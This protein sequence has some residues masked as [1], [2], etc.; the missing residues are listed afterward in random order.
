MPQDCSELGQWVPRHAGCATACLG[1]ECV[2][3][4]AGEAMCKDGA[5][6]ECTAGQWN[7]LEL[8]GKACEN[9]A[10]V[11]G[12]TEDRL[13]CNGARWL[14]KCV[15]GSYVDE[16]ECPF[17]CSEGACVGEC[18]PD[19][20]RC[21][22]DAEGESQTCGADALWGA[23][24]PC[25]ANTFCVA[26]GCKPCRPGTKRCSDAGPQQCSEA[27]EWVNQG[28][29]V[30][31][32]PACLNGACVACTPGE[33]RCAAAAVEQCLMDGSGWERVAACS[34]A[35]PVCLETTKACGRCTQGQTQ[36]FG[37]EVRSCDDQGVWTTTQTCSGTTP[38]CVASACV[39]CDPAAGERRCETQNRAQSCSAAGSWGN[40]TTCSGDKPL[41]REDLN[42]SCGCEEGQRRCRTNTIP[43]VC[44]GGS[45]V[46]QTTCSGVLNHCL[47]ASG[48]CVDCVPGT[49]ECQSGTAYECTAQGAWRS[50]NSCAGPGINCGGCDLGEPCRQNSDCGSGVCV[51]QM[52][53][54]CQPGQRR[55]QGNVPQ[56]CSASGAWTN[57]SAC[58]G[59]TPQCLAST[60]LCVECLSGSRACGTCNGGT[61]T[62]G[63]NNAW[64]TCTNQP[65][66]QSSNAHCGA[67]N[68]ACPSGRSCQSG[69]CQCNSGTHAC[70]TTCYSNTDADRCGSGCVDCSAYHGTSNVCSGN[71]CACSVGS[72]ACGAN[73]PTCSSWDF[74]T[75]TE[76]WKRGSYYGPTQNRL[77]TPFSTVINNGSPAL[78]AHFEYDGMATRGVA[79]FSVDLCPNGS[80]TDL[81]GFDFSYKVYF[82]TT[83]SLRFAASEYVV[84]TFL[85]DG[86]TVITACQPFLYPSSDTWET[87]SCPSMPANTRN[88]TI[89]VRFNRAWTGDIYLDDVRFTPRR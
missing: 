67:C 3:C 12:C 32:T 5:V 27:G 10:C 24:E 59:A 68:N 9:G 49:A 47:P 33:K 8:C 51:N 56:L 23:S 30:A 44:Q 21:N 55:C 86:G 11:A 38:R 31:P 26:G 43:E 6:Q 14:Q 83:T 85:A 20:R 69:S 42:F 65:N 64:G 77:T 71:Q 89:V 73:V 58:S 50:L 46:A 82:R 72:F 34:G 54:V 87:G 16:T 78:T 13:Q 40:P 2:E 15:G 29:C 39:Q 37:N 45:W 63:T 1:G 17:S 74:T 61:Q 41:C 35:T 57:Q 76:G 25:P 22:P 88:L 70:G 66:L 81:S 48:Q 80:S 18:M 28:A 19:S 52:C 36:C 79:E 62:C 53:A 60:G 75:G 84:D 7:T 4:V